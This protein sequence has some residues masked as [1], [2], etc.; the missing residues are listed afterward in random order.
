MKKHNCGWRYASGHI[1]DSDLQMC[2]TVGHISELTN[3]NRMT[4]KGFSIGEP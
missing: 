4:K 1:M 2:S 3:K